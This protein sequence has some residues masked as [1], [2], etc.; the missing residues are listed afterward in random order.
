MDIEIHFNEYVTAQ[1]LR[2][3]RRYNLSVAHMIAISIHQFIGEL[4]DVVEM[5]LADGGGSQWSNC[6]IADTTSV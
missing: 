4:P 3:A 5:S 6:E 1:I 2:K